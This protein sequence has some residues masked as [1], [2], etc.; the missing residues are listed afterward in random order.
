MHIENKSMDFEVIVAFA[1]FGLGLISS[2]SAGLVWLGNQQKRTWA[3]ERDIAH[4]RRNQEQL[5]QGMS[6]LSDE[7]DEL[8]NR[9]VQEIIE[10]KALSYRQ[11][12]KPHA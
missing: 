3:L 10:L 7:M 11:L 6:S 9:L 2:L 4:V 8:H 5:V 12:T 1:S